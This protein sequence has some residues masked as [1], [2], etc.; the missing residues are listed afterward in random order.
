MIE[1][2]IMREIGPK[3]GEGVGCQSGFQG[4][5]YIENLTAIEKAKISCR[6]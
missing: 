6:K 2:V 1:D 4:A 5:I 3:M